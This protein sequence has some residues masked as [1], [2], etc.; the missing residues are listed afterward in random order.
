MTIHF[1]QLFLAH[2]QEHKPNFLGAQRRC[3]ELCE[4][5]LHSLELSLFVFCE[6][7]IPPA[8]TI[9]FHG[10]DKLPRGRVLRNRGAHQ[11]R[12][13]FSGMACEAQPLGFEP[14]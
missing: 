7:E 10:G 4:T 8:Y 14:Q 11:A 2:R 1:A 9:N 3:A 5:V 12:A 13:N 6:V